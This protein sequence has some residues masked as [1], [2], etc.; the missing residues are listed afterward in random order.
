MRRLSLSVFLCLAACGGGVKPA[1]TGAVD[2]STDLRAE[3]QRYLFTADARAAIA[4]FATVSSQ[5]A[6]DSCL[7]AWVDDEGGQSG[8]NEP[9]EKPDV[10]GLRSF[11]AQCL[12]VSVPVDMRAASPS[13][14]RTAG[15]G[16]NF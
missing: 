16:N 7:A 9:I 12:G 4:E 6:L 8:L 3:Y 5:D 15:A 14:M 13:S 11:L 1:S 10:K 2:P